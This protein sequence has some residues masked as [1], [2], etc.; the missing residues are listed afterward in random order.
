MRLS[1]EE[2]AMLAGVLGE[3]RRWAMSHQIAVGGLEANG[4]LGARS[5]FEGG[6]TALAAP[7]TGR[8]RCDGCALD[9]CRRGRRGFR[10]CAA[11]RGRGGWGALG[12]VVGD[13]CSCY[14]QVPVIEG[15]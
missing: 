12:G 10:L 7:L 11:P 3:P 8:T 1:D 4:G 14:W 9:A 13:A 2:R 5:T 6:R 15:F